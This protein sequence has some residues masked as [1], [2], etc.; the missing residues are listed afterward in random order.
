[1]PT[2]VAFFRRREPPVRNDQ[3]RPLP[4]CLMG[5]VAPGCTQG[6]ISEPAPSG[7]STRQPFLPQHPRRVQA[8]NNDPAVG[9]G[10]ACCQDV[11]VMGAD[12]IDPAMQPGHLHGGCA[13]AREPLVQRESARQTCRSS[14]NAVSNGRGFS[15]RSITVPSLVATLAR[16]RTPTSTPTRQSGSAPLG[17]WGRWTT[18][19]T[20][21]SI[22][23]RLPRTEIASTRAR[24]ARMRRSTRR[25]F[26]CVR[27]CRSPAA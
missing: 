9:F 6:R 19:R 12:I 18:T 24:P 22:R 14:R 13:V 27:Q 2:G 8:V 15:T 23:V 11:R 4:A 5:Q 20:L 21:A 16:R 3:F 1:M 17:C 25:V 7:A 26:S 10:Q